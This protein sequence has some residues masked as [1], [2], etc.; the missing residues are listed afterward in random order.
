M[1]RLPEPKLNSAQQMNWQ[2]NCMEGD[3]RGSM[4]NTPPPGERGGGFGNVN[5]PTTPQRETRENAPPRS[6]SLRER[7]FRATN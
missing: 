7:M 1:A 4:N 2:G 3:G 6:P 5:L